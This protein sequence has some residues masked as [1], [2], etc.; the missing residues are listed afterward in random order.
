MDAIPSSAGLCHACRHARLIVSA[1]G[2]RFVQC[3]ASSAD[4]R[5]SKYPT[6]PRLTCHAYQPEDGDQNEDQR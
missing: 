2:S 3:Q 1:K 5:L 4:Q 6:L